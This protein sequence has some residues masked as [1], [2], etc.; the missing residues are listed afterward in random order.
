MEERMKVIVKTNDQ[1]LLAVYETV[2]NS[3]E[4]PY[5]IRGYEAASL[6]PLNAAIVVP[7]E[8]AEQ[9]EALLRE[10]QEAHEP[11]SA[12]GDEA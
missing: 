4:I 6:M 9:A 12:E 5:F 3:A 10:T 11:P 2:L 7:K 1:G 8:F